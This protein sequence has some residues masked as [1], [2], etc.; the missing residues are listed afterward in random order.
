MAD[1]GVPAARLAEAARTAVPIPQ[2]TVDTGLDLEEAY[3]VQAAGVALHADRGDRPVGVKL[4]FTSKAKAERMGVSDVIIGVVT[5][6]MQVTDS[7]VVDM[8]RMIHPVSSPRWRS[9]W[10]ATST[11]AIPATTRWPQ[12]TRW[13][14]PW[15]S[16]TAA[17]ATSGSA[18]PTVVA[19]N[20][21]ACAFVIGPWQQ[22]ASADL[23][24]LA[25]GPHVDGEAVA[26]GSSADLL[27]HPE[28]AL[29]AVKRTARLHGT[30]PP[31]GAVVPAGAATAAAP[32][33]AGAEVVATVGD[34][35]GVSVRTA[36]TARRFSDV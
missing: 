26:T 29:E 35:G 20:T 24:G 3:A 28:R 21:S 25:V 19:D 7:G 4:G 15:R 18:R 8:V 9:A 16:S 6:G 1:R 14:R 32:L 27:G 36:G 23:A 17:T 10:A 5:S 30:A 11:P 12:W 31:A 33:A 2:L 13:R 34:L 22:P